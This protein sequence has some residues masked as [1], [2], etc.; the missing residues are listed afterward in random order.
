MTV[1]YSNK[2][3]WW[4]ALNDNKPSING[5]KWFTANMTDIKLKINYDLVIHAGDHQM[6]HEWMIKEWWRNG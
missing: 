4:Y 1:K 3:I 2:F 6:S 5:F